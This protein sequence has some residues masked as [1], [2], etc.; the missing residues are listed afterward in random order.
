MLENLG[1]GA[2]IDDS[3]YDRIYHCMIDRLKDK[4]AI[5]RVHSVLALKRLQDPSDENCP[6][7]KGVYA[8]E[9]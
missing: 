7:T 6:I 8:I 1:E 9:C 5:V 3:L 4:C 2:K